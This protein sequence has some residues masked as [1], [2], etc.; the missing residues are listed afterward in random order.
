[1]AARLP[2]GTARRLALAVREETLGHTTTRTPSDDSDCGTIRIRGRP[3]F[4]A[5]PDRFFGSPHHCPGSPT[6]SR[7]IGSPRRDSMRLGLVVALPELV[8]AVTRAPGTVWKDRRERF[9]DGSFV[10][11]RLSGQAAGAA[12]L[13]AWAGAGEA[14]ASCSA[15]AV[16][17][18]L[19]PSWICADSWLLL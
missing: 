2:G 11:Q 10:V 16:V 7:H 6:R 15:A 12:L 8:R 4:L 13:L 5:L 14:C 17:A 18:A 19:L 1:V 3:S 9:R